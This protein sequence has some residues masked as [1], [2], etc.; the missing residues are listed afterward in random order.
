MA[1]IGICHFRIGETDG[2]SLEIEKCRL[3][4]QQLGHQVFLC[5]G[6]LGIG[7]EAFVIPELA[8][9]HPEI[10]KIRKNAFLDFSEYSSEEDFLAHIED[11]A[12]RIETGIKRFVTDCALDLFIVHN[13]WSL[14]IN[15]PASVGV[16]RAAQALHLPVIAHHHDFYWEKEDY[17]KPTCLLVQD[18]LIRYYPPDSHRVQHVVI[19]SLAQQEL[20]RR[21]VNAAII[22]NV[23]DFTKTLDKKDL[24][25]DFMEAIG[26]SPSDVVFLQAT[27]VVRRKGIEIAIELVAR[28]ASPQYQRN[29]AKYVRARGGSP[30]A[31]PVLLLPNLVE[32]AE[33]FALLQERIIQRGVDAR[34]VADRVA[35]ERQHG[36]F[37]FWDAYRCADFVTY[38]SLQ[39]GW[40]NQ[41]LEAFWARLPIAVYEY[42]VFRT[43]IAPLGFWYVSLGNTYER[44]EKGLARVPERVLCRAAEEIASLLASPKRYRQVVDHNYKLAK[45]HFSIE[46]LAERYGELVNAI[47]G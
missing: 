38:P 39:E 40:G 9:G 43:D 24:P 15:I 13:I 31:R 32:D 7:A 47:L 28:L 34:F 25:S 18:L 33:Y 30:R 17:S 19:N 36:R 5:A 2:V 29:L 37:S 35:M 42:P 45:S 41:L 21:G 8:I 23:F 3:A 4:L 16:W 6:H 26:L 11:V 44:D 12:T 20:R 1:R 14:P 46:V 27:R 22:P 10:V